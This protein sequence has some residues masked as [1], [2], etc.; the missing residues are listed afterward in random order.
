[1]E[2][3]ESLPSFKSWLNHAHGTTSHK[4]MQQEHIKARNGKGFRYSQPVEGNINV[5][6]NLLKRCFN[7]D[8]PNYRWTSGIMYI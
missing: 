2:R 7:V 3:L 8:R 5:A 4:L 1:M 6:A